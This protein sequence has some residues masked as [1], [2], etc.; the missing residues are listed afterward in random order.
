M[1]AFQKVST[2]HDFMLKQKEQF[3]EKKTRSH[4]QEEHKQQ[5]KQL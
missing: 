5:Q 2:E 1:L 4:K 3:V